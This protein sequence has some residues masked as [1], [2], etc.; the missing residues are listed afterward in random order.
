MGFA[1]A[2]SDTAAICSRSQLRLSLSTQR[3]ATQSVIFLSLRNRGPMT[4]LATGV[5]RFE[6]D[7]AAR[8]AR[9]VGNP[10]A[11]PVRVRIS[12]QR[13]RP[14]AHVW[15]ANWCGARQGLVAFVHYSGRVVRSRLRSPPACLSSSQR[16]TL[17]LPAH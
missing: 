8:R 7:Q 2:H 10:L 6:I 12:S 1:S 16:S 13:L 14:A 15:W 3:T 4:C 11:A 5:A 9:I 17:S